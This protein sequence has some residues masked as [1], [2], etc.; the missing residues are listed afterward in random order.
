MSSNPLR[1][2]SE[3]CAFEVP[4][5]RPTTPGS[6]PPKFIQKHKS[7]SPREIEEEIVK[8]QQ[9]ADARRKVNQCLISRG[10]M[11]VELCII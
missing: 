8:R 10:S 6:S 5:E 1:K 7:K 9:E 4:I 11:V 2:S 3:G